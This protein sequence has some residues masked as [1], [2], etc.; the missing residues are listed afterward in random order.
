MAMSSSIIGARL[1]PIAP[2]GAAVALTV[3]APAVSAGRL[4]VAGMSQAVG[5][6]IRGA[7]VTDAGQATS[8]YV[9]RTDRTGRLAFGSAVR[10][11]E[12]DVRVSLSNRASFVGNS[13]WHSA[14]A[15]GNELPRPSTM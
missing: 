8:H 1:V 6:A 5:L 14:F 10:G 2:L 3:A 4:D 11:A 7:S 9:M 15:V 12:A 13:L